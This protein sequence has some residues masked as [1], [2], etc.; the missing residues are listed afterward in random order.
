[1]TQ[2]QHE[3]IG[4]DT[5]QGTIFRCTQCNREIMITNGIF[6]V[7]NRGEDP[8]IPHTGFTFVSG[9]KTERRLKS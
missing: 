9:E 6:K 3:C 2:Q 1:M 8:R 5:D 4:E 7:L